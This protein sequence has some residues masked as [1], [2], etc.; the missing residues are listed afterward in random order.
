MKIVIISFRAHAVALMI[1]Q[2]HII[3][4]ICFWVD[5]GAG[6]GIQPGI[7]NEMNLFDLLIRIWQKVNY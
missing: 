3:V 4:G 7:Q 1:E 5:V 6:A 2:I